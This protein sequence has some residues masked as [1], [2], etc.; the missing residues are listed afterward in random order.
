ML[1]ASFVIGPRLR[2]HINRQ[3]LLAAKVQGYL[4]EHVAA[5]ETIKSLQMETEVA[6]RYQELNN[7]YLVSARETK[8][9]AN[10][11]SVYMSL[12]EQLMNATVIC[13]GAYL[14][15]T[16]TTLTIGML[17]AFQMFAQRVTQPLLRLSGAWQELQQVRVSVA[18]LGDMMNAIP[19]RYS[20][21]A[22]S[23]GPSEG[24]LEVTGL[25]FRYAQDRPPL[26]KDLSFTVTPGAVTLITG[27]SGSGKSTLAKIL[28]GLYP[29]YEGIV[30]VDGRDTRSMTANEIRRFFGVVP[31]ETVLFSGT[32]LENLL[33]G[34]PG[35]TLEMASHA[36]RMAGIHDAI[37]N[38]PQG[39]LTE[40]GERGVGLSGGQR[41]RVGIARALLKRPKV[42]IFD[43][44]TSGLDEVAAH[45]IAQTVN[46]MRGKV[47]V[48]FIAHR[49]PEPLRHDGHLDLAKHAGA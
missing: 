25:S 33:S 11:Y 9:L 23:T 36:C 27:P 38:M 40:L 32:I 4:T 43:E 18:M 21:I 20:A 15:M 17:V 49:I 30:K 31:Q 46:E 29:D 47:T 44:S 48:L 6:G 41:Q 8:E 2:S 7:N 26:Y 16:T 34:A 37:I 28:L 35:S 5:T 22:T 3:S 19:E 45:K 12:M 14:A 42:L 1:S 13:V 10:G 24:K 39:Y